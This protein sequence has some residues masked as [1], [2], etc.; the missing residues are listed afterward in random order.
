VTT[1]SG[2]P[3]TLR[4]RLLGSPSPSGGCA[5]VY[6]TGQELDDSV[7]IGRDGAEPHGDPDRTDRAILEAGGKPGNREVSA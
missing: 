7:D 5:S 1:S 2:A 6:V 4:L 3:E